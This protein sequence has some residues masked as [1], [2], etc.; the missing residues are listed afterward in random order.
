[1]SNEYENRNN[2]VIEDAT[3]LDDLFDAP[4]AE[5][6]DGKAPTEFYYTAAE[7]ADDVT[8]INFDDEE[9]E[10]E[11]EP[12]KK[13]SKQNKEKKKKPGLIILI[14]LLILGL[15]VA[16][17]LKFFGGKKYEV[18]FKD[19]EGTVI[20][21]IKIK[22]GY[23]V[24]LP[25]APKKEGFVFIEW[26]LNGKKYD[27]TSTVGSNIT[28]T[29]F[30]KRAI[31]VTFLNEDRSEFKVIEIAEGD[32]LE[33]P[34]T[35]PEVKNK[36]FVAWLTEDGNEYK[37]DKELNE[38]LTLIAKMK[39]YIK[40]TGLAYANPDQRIYVNEEKPIRPVVTPGNTTEKIT[41]S[42]SDTSIFT[43]DQNGV[44]KGIKAGKAT[45][46]AKVEDLVATTTIIVEEK[47][48]TAVIFQEGNNVRIAKGKTLTLHTL[49]TP[50][51]ATN[52]D[53]T[54]TSSDE[55]IAKVSKE[56]VVTAVKKGKCFITA[57]A[58]N[59]VSYTTT[60]DVFVAVERI[61]LSYDPTSTTL[62]Y[63]G[64]NISIT[65]TIYPSDADV[66]TV[67]WKTQSNAGESRIF[68]TSV[69]GNSISISAGDGAVY[70][71][72][73]TPTMYVS[74]TADG[75]ESAVVQVYAEATPSVTYCSGTPA[76]ND[77]YTAAVGDMFYLNFSVDGTITVA[78][79]SLFSSMDITSSGVSAQISEAGTTEIT[80]VSYAGQVYTIWLTT[81]E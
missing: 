81:T 48:V 72:G 53:I 40:P 29:A 37:F 3:S 49:I 46:T 15:L 9:Y 14:I 70:Y 25:E 66:K 31:K 47:P 64:G 80:M 28:L 7:D 36:A 71:S 39:D 17:Y 32:K 4:A 24:E 33:R 8:E 12:K 38:D 21:T 55:T 59:G 58:H 57:T 76:G 23:R 44:V 60:V 41:Y 6:P 69:N 52:K 27:E 30:Y 77:Q 34:D 68:N 73:P 1:M 78:N 42:S 65:A 35:V 10:D 56:G 67:E 74:A 51:D 5:Y 61:E 63:G 19:S 43:V 26:Q 75:V 20:E 45:L 13:K 18:S 11:I 22:E 79:G 2:E 50:E 62:Y 54:Y 16:G